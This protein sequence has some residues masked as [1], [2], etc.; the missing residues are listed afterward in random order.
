MSKSSVLLIIAQFT[1]IGFLVWNDNIIQ[2][3]PIMLAIQLIGVLIAIWGVLTIKV[4]NFNIQPEVKSK[5][6]ISKGP[7]RWIRNPMYLGI[8]IVFLLPVIRNQSLTQW[9]AF[10]LL[11]IVLLIKIGREEQLLYERFRES[12][13]VYK[14]KSWRLIPF[15]F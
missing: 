15:V 7:F 1:L 2:R 4:G 14:K 3:Q 9:L 8:L 13:I 5:I 12:Y 10:V 11:I 6:L